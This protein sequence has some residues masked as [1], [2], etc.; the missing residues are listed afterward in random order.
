MTT[1][2]R[3]IQNREG[4]VVRQTS[5]PSWSPAQAVDVVVGL[6][7]L[8]LGAVSLAHTGFTFR[9]IPFTRTTVMGLPIT[10][11]SAL[12]ELVAGVLVLAGAASPLASKSL[13]GVLGIILLAW[14]LIVAI[15]PTPFGRLWGYD[16]GSGILYIV[17]GVILLLAA[18]VSPIFASRRNSVVQGVVQDNVQGDDMVLP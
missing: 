18:A 15:D 1:S 6:F 8:V 3:H 4:A 13:S 10:S 9:N 11:L 16:R 2:A 12:V 14:G 5:R 7:L 17:L